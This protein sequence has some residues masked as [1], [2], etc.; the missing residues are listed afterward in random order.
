MSQ[1]CT[2]CG[3][4]V[5]G[6]AFCTSCGAPQAASAAP[7][8]V[9]TRVEP[10]N[11]TR[12]MTQ[13]TV[14][15]STQPASQSVSSKKKIL[16]YAVAFIVILGCGIGGFFVGKGSIDLKKERSVAYETGYQEGQV[17]GY[18]EG[19]LNGISNGR[20]MGY[21]DGFKKG[22]TAGC[23]AAYSFFDGSWD[24]IVPYDIYARR[25]T[26]G[27]YNSRIGCD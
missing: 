11:M 25:M 1:F 2:S 4:Q 26:G 16:A 6:A 27:Y 5:S 21:N 14:S 15:D 3:A 22:K 13:T 9:Q 24:H 7:P 8:E 20:E 19:Q 17:A 23:N 12:P 10:V 18:Q